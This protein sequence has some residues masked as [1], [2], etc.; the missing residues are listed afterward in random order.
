MA[1]EVIRWRGGPGSGKSTQLLGYV[2][3]EIDSG[4]ALSDIAVM[5]FSRSQAA[6]LAQRLGRLSPDESEKT[7]RSMCSTI[8]SAALRECMS[9]GLINNP[10]EQIIQPGRAKGHVYQKFMDTWELDYIPT[11]GTDED[12]D[13]RGRDTPIGNCVVAIDAYLRATMRDVS[14]WRDAA[15]N[16]NVTSDATCAYDIPH[17]VASWRDYKA[18]GGY[19][20]HED[21]VELVI[22]RSVRP[23][24]SVILVDEFQDVSPAQDALIRQWIEHPDTVRVY[25]AGDQDQSIYSFRGCDPRLFVSL[26][27]RDQGAVDAQRRPVSHRCPVRIMSVAEEILGH[28]ANVSPAPRQGVVHHLAMTSPD[29]LARQVENAVEHAQT[30]P[31]GRDV[32]VL[33]RFR[34]G[35][36]TLAMALSRVGIPCTSI[37]PGRIRLWEKVRLGVDK[38]SLEATTI[39]PWTLTRALSR[40]IRGCDIDVIPTDEAETLMLSALRGRERD[41]AA[42]KLKTKAKKSAIRLGDV[43]S[44]TGGSRGTELIAD[45]NLRPWVIRQVRAC[46]ERES[47]RGYEISPDRVRVDTIHASKGL[48]CGVAI[49]HTQY[50]K[51]LLDGLAV[52]HRLAEER[53][54]YFVGATRASSALV[55]LDYGTPI[56]PI[57]QG[58]GA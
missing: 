52:P 29:Q 16:L 41:V 32:F 4:V 56:C 43:Y 24:A 34:D 42:T 37:K 38:G 15:A 6:D 51:G 49:L 31:K 21:Y 3:S 7:I 39:N 46:L 54:V 45:M 26:P 1:A 10:R 13:P 9:I 19:F 22:D 40:Y 50:L 8:H 48:E 28:A 12:D 17:L 14:A 25:V 33:S 47:R 36:H 57:L 20:E 30:L 44:W 23:P 55:L 18:K 53:R 5:T 2:Q 58:V 27:A 35:A 11:L